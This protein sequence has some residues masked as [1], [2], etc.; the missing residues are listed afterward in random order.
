MVAIDI[1]FQRFPSIQWCAEQVRSHIF[2]HLPV[3]EL[4]SVGQIE[5]ALVQLLPER[6]KNSSDPCSLVGREIVHNIMLF[7]HR[8][9]MLLL[10]IDCFQNSQVSGIFVSCRRIWHRL[11]VQRTSVLDLALVLQC[12]HIYPSCGYLITL[13]RLAA[14]IRRL[15][16]TSLLECVCYLGKIDMPHNVV[17]AILVLLALITRIEVLRAPLDAVGSADVAQS[18]QLGLACFGL[19][20]TPC[21]RTPSTH[22]KDGQ[23]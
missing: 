16:V 17:L 6:M 21:R 14:G 11:G 15:F 22:P 4:H 9:E 8:C 12:C 2:T 23:I 20:A 1:N 10:Q 5:A 13:A 3:P 19:D 7:I 18:T